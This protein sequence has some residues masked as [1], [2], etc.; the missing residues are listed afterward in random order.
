MIDRDGVIRILA[1]LKT[2]LASKV[3]KVEGKGLSTND[4]TDLH[5]Q[6]LEKI[7]GNGIRVSAGTLYIDRT[8]EGSGD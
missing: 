1:I 8:I 3:S 6:T 7:S 2:T 4:F 5:K